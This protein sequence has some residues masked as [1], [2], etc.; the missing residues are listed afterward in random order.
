[1]GLDDEFQNCVGLSLFTII[2]DIAID[3]LAELVYN[4]ISHMEFAQGMSFTKRLNSAV[5]I[6]PSLS[7]FRSA[8]LKFAES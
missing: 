7:F 1:M 2:R 6:S 5:S 3:T 4:A 8:A